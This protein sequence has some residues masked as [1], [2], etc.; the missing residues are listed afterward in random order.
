VQLQ[1]AFGARA[2]AAAALGLD[3]LGAFGAAISILQICGGV[4]LTRLVHVF[5]GGLALFEEQAV[6]LDELVALGF[7]VGGQL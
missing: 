5:V 2:G 3:F 7:G 6:F 4:S 1:I